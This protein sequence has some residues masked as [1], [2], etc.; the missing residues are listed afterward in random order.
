MTSYLFALVD[1]GRTVPP[2]LGAAASR[3]GSGA[4]SGQRIRRCQEAALDGVY[5]IAEAKLSAAEQARTPCDE[6]C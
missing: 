5:R 4:R 1:G 2:E 6:M 3:R